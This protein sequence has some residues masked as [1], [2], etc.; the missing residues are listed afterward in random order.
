MG[1]ISPKGQACGWGF[2][3]WLPTFQVC[4]RPEPLSARL[5]NG[6]ATDPVPG[7]VRTRG[8]RGCKKHFGAG[9]DNASAPAPP[10]STQAPRA[11]SLP[12]PASRLQCP[13]VSPV[14]MDRPWLGLQGSLRSTKAGT[15]VAKAP[16]SAR[17]RERL[18]SEGTVCF[19]GPLHHSGW[20]GSS[21]PP[22]GSYPLSAA[23]P[24]LVWPLW[25]WPIPQAESVAPRWAQ[26]LLCI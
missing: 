4:R 5:C 19:R 13:L 18:V 3:S 1:S 17:N 10:C 26:P 2:R 24:L 12:H 11:S 23:W 16:A 15:A 7:G 9:K 21:G 20:C 6:R 22:R 25:L 14:L 8:R